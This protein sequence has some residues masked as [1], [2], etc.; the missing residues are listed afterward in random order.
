M[1]EH[2]LYLYSVFIDL[3]EAATG[4]RFFIYIKNERKGN[5]RERV[6]WIVVAHSFP[7]G[8]LQLLVECSDQRKK[9]RIICIDFSDLHG[10]FLSVASARTLCTPSI[11][12]F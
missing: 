6:Q 3:P 4:Y 9:I 5:R 12:Y 11:L 8:G 10:Q 7:V 2:S 1:N